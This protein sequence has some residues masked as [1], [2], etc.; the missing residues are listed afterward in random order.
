L[1][2]KDFYL[3]FSAIRYMH[4]KD[5]AGSYP[6]EREICMLATKSYILAR[7]R[8]RIRQIPTNEKSKI[9]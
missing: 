5:E 4:H 1:N 3:P 9:K 7:K 2:I 8:E 6:V